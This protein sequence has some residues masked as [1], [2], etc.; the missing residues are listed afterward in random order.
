MPQI[1]HILDK[2]QAQDYPQVGRYE[3][4][5]VCSDY[6]IQEGQLCA[7]VT[8]PLSSCSY[9]LSLAYPGYWEAD[10]QRTCSDSNVLYALICTCCCKRSLSLHL[11]IGRLRCTSF[12]LQLLTLNCCIYCLVWSVVL[13]LPFNFMNGCGGLKINDYVISLH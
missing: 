5:C 8:Y 2:F 7:L 13:G 3:I 1:K 10:S 12:D 6:W 11:Q 9:Q 4:S